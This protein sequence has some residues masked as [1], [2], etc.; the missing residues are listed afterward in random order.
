[1]AGPKFV[2]TPSHLADVSNSL[3]TLSDSIG[4][5]QPVRLPAR[6][7][8]QGLRMQGLGG[9]LARTAAPHESVAAREQR[10]EED[11]LLHFDRLGI[12]RLRAKQ[13][14]TAKGDSASWLVWLQNL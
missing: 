6:R 10:I 9:R 13:A 11:V 14:R 7:P 4:K 8:T 5:V 2:A 3:A 1:M 12:Q